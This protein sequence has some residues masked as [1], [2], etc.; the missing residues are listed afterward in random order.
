MNVELTGTDA[1]ARIKITE[2]DGTTTTFKRGANLEGNAKIFEWI[3]DTVTGG[4]GTETQSSS[5][6][7]MGEPRW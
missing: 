4:N 3:T 5:P 1:S 2:D 6:I 7:P